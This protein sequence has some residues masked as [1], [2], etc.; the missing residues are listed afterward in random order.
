MSLICNKEILLF[1]ALSISFFDFSSKEAIDN[2]MLDFRILIS[3]TWKDR[4]GNNIQ[5]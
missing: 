4:I 5:I 2:Q 3:L 1:L